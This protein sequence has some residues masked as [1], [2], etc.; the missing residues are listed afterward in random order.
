MKIVSNLLLLAAAASFTALASTSPYGISIEKLFAKAE[1]TNDQTYLNLAVYRCSALLALVNG[2]VERDTGTTKNNGAS[3]DLLEF[4]FYLTMKQLQERGGKI[5]ED[6]VFSRSKASYDDHYSKYYDWM[7]KNYD[8]FGDY[9]GT[10]QSL[11][12]E[13]TSC[14]TLAKQI[15]TK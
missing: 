2:I 4:G 1:A 6:A 12:S 8:A 9:W 7:V 10:D 14:N 3:Q 11:Q 13:I 15:E 5:D